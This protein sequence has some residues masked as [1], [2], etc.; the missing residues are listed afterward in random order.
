MENLPSRV[1]TCYNGEQQTGP[2]YL[3]GLRKG[4]RGEQG[5][6]VRHHWE[7]NRSTA[8]ENPMEAEW[9]EI[10]SVPYDD[11][12]LLWNGN[13]IQMGRK[14][15]P[16]FYTD[17][18][19]DDGGKIDGTVSHWMAIPFPPYDWVCSQCGVSGMGFHACDVS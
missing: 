14:I 17:P 1:L 4:W 11:P 18:M 12:V 7:T 3:R 5:V 9:K 19:P 13:Y 6:M 10:A 16:F 15:G 8:L 2:M